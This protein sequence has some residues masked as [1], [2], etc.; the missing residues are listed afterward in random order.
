MIVFHQKTW[1]Q[2]LHVPHRSVLPVQPAQQIARLQTDRHRLT[3]A[4]PQPA[5]Y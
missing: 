3:Q 4:H 2:K 5:F 1:R